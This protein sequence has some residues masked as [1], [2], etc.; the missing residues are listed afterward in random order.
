MGEVYKAT[1]I[2]L[3]PTVAIK[4]LTGRAGPRFLQKARAIAALPVPT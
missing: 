2:R 3:R 4:T 1:D